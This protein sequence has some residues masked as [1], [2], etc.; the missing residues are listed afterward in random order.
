[1]R[2]LSA[3]GAQA[4]RESACEPPGRRGLTAA[5]FKPTPNRY[6]EHPRDRT[7]PEQ[8]KQQRHR[9]APNTPLRAIHGPPRTATLPHTAARCATRQHNVALCK[10][11]RCHAACKTSSPRAGA[12]K[13]RASTSLRITHVHVYGRPALSRRGHRGPTHH[14][15]PRG[16]PWPRRFGHV[17]GLR[18]DAVRTFG[19]ARAAR[20]CACCAR[21]HSRARYAPTRAGRLNRCAVQ[22][23]PESLSR[24][25]HRTA[26]ARGGEFCEG[27]SLVSSQ[28]SAVLGA[29]RPSPLRGCA[30]RSL[31][32]PARG[33]V[34][35][36]PTAITY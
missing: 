22:A 31:D 27:C 26:T 2:R 14:R 12:G 20:S 6:A 1:M 28:G 18:A 34:E 16:H 24:R 25:S 17:R 3:C 29:S 35:R 21:P 4:E 15:R 33:A 8:Q 13:R 11:P 19:R 36:T 9:G 23:E 30:A 7:P 5:R 32:P 10:V